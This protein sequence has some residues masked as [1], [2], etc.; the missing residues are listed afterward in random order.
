MIDTDA[1]R[2]E[3]L[4]RIRAAILPTI[5]RDYPHLLAKARQEPTPL[6]ETTAQAGD[7]DTPS[8]W[9]AVDLTAILAGT[10]VRPQTTIL[11]RSDG[12]RL[13]YPGR[14]H[15]VHGESES[16]KS[17]VL[18]HAGSEVLDSGGRV[19]YLDFETDAASVVDRLLTLGVARDV[20]G[21]RFAYLSPDVNP[22]NSERAREDF[23]K[24]VRA[25]FDLVVID[26][27]TDALGVF[28]A[29]TREEDE[30]A[31]FMR[32]LPRPFARAGAC[33]VLVDHVSKGNDERGRFAI[34]SQHKMAALDGAAYVVEAKAAFGRGLRGESDIRVA[35]DKPG[36]VR[37]H[38]GQFRASD[39]TQAVARFVLDETREGHMIVS[40]T[41]PEPTKGADAWRPTANM[42]RVSRWLDD[43]PGTT[44]T[45]IATGTKLNGERVQEAL[46]YLMGEGLVN[47][48][49]GK[50]RDSH[51]Y[52]PANGGYREANDEKSDAYV[53]GIGAVDNPGEESLVDYSTGPQPVTAQST[54]LANGSAVNQSATS[55]EA[56]TAREPVTS[57]NASTSQPVTDQ[58]NGVDWFPETPGGAQPVNQ[59]P[60][61]E[62]GDGDRLEPPVSPTPQYE[63]SVT[64][65]YGGFRVVEGP[66][67]VEAG[68]LR[69]A[70]RVDCQVDGQETEGEA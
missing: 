31:R 37:P 13:L 6:E 51:V 65:L 16:A 22:A 52:W 21:E 57:T 60:P 4:N 58:S 43:H 2:E 39:R 40:L 28:G 7:E 10:Y 3:S 45:A 23:Q 35:K 61:L 25:S 63:K 33:V 1:A 9:G 20:L 24:L 50:R 47:A 49:P 27:T 41:P 12:V 34:G 66:E 59:S 46:E 42:D 67:T 70:G 30:V 19:C 64:E 11:R 38:G 26:G 8:S 15:S 44:K 56:K 18:M 68:I 54:P 14:V 36:A 62:E 32:T 48:E 29:S 53:W 17:W 69:A 55:H 5:Q